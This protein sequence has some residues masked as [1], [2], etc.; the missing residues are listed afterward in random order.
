MAEKRNLIR[1][2]KRITLKFGVNASTKVAFTEDL[3]PNGLFVKTGSP[4][5][6]GTRIKMEL[7]MPDKNKVLLEG[8]I[9][10]RKTGPLQAIHLNIKIGM[11]VKILKFISGEEHYRG[12][13]AEIK[14]KS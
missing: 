2:K 3:S 8:M 12:Y 4:L 7:T 9:R 1:L 14:T 5:P 6:P 10:W 13:I 11:G